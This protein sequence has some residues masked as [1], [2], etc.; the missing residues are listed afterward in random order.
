MKSSALV[1]AAALVVFLGWLGWLAYLAIQARAEVVLSRP[2]LLVSNLDV[3]ADVGKTVKIEE[4]HWPDTEEGRKGQT[5]EVTNL[6]ACDGWIGPGRYI[7]PLTPDGKDWRVTQ[8]PRSPGYS[9]T[10][11]PRIYPVTPETLRQLDECRKP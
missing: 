8:T 6:S 1:F 3:I 2:Q 7:L 4:V 11:K 10:A 9:G 5:I